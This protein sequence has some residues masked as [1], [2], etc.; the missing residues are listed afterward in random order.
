VLGVRAVGRCGVLV[1]NKT[2]VVGAY[3]GVL[4]GFCEPFGIAC[5][6]FVRSCFV[7]FLQ[8]RAGTNRHMIHTAQE[9]R[10]GD[11]VPIRKMEMEME[12]K[13]CRWEMCANKDGGRLMSE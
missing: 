1:W 10:I 6:L 3:D 9:R 7:L 11:V 12:S 13:I 8:G 4:L 2:A 5:V